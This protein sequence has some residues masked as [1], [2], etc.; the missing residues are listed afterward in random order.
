PRAVAVAGDAPEHADPDVFL[1]AG[2]L[3]PVVHD[4]GAE[5]HGPPAPLA[6][7]RAGDEPAIGVGHLPDARIIDDCDMIVLGQLCSPQA[8]Q[9]TRLYAAGEAEV[10]VRRL[11]PWRAPLTAVEARHRALVAGQVQRRRKPSWAATNYQH[12]GVKI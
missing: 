7:I 2:E 4:P 11:R 8:A 9:L 12:F 5:Y 6:A 10:V 3:G 1:P